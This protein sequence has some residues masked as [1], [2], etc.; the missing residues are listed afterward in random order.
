MNNQIMIR[1]ARLSLAVLLIASCGRTGSLPDGP[2]GSMPEVGEDTDAGPAPVDAGGGDSGAPDASV[3]DA[4][5]A[6]AGTYDAGLCTLVTRAPA[7]EL[8]KSPR[9]NPSLE[10]LVLH[11][12][13]WLFVVDD[14]T[15]A[16][17]EQEW[18]QW[19]EPDGGRPG[20]I[21]S[22]GSTL[23]LRFDATGSAEVNAGTYRAWDCLNA[24]YRGTPTHFT[25]SG[26]TLAFVTLEP[27]VSLPQLGSDYAA[28]PHVVSVKPDPFGICAACGCNTDTCLDLDPD[29]GTWVWLGYSESNHCEHRWLRRQTEADGGSRLELWTDAGLPRH[30]L[31]Q[32]PRCW[33]QL[34]SAYGR[35]DAGP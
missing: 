21:A 18:A 10:L 24:A 27:V 29:A 12:A 35:R 2:D 16:R 31:D 25:L 8:A 4:G 1:L 9:A 33:D 19:G 5:P 28:L 11:G 26:G 15:Y 14:A 7:S 17:V 20:F 30:W 22:W 32:S 34:W 6:D 3:R 13:P 23:D